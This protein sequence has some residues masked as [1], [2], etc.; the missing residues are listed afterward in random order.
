MLEEHLVQYVI[1]LKLCPLWVHEKVT[2]RHVLL[3]LLSTFRISVFVQNHVN[4]NYSLRLDSVLWNASKIHMSNAHDFVAA[5]EHT[6]LWPPRT[7]NDE[8]FGEKRPP[9]SQVKN[10]GELWHGKSERGRTRWLI[11][12][13]VE[14]DAF[15]ADE[16][17]RDTPSVSKQMSFDHWQITIILHAVWLKW[18]LLLTF[19][20]GGCTASKMLEVMKLGPMGSKPHLLW[21]QTTL[22]FLCWNQRTLV[23]EY[24]KVKPVKQ[25][26][27]WD[28]ARS[29]AE[30]PRWSRSIQFYDHDQYFRVNHV[31]QSWSQ[32]GTDFLPHLSDYIPTDVLVHSCTSISQKDDGVSN[33]SLTL[34]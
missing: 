18:F 33:G 15:V 23:K 25:N 5:H 19:W 31:S 10:L 20:S 26:M 32:H 16:K 21:L 28:L 34:E 13:K 9:K 14:T 7:L 17:K 2:K 27:F 4:S 8:S 30:R 29:A 1:C 11:S 3:N 6:L 12:E 24:N 22:Q